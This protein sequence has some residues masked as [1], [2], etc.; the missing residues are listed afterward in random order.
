METGTAVVLYDPPAHPFSGL[1]SGP[2]AAVK[3]VVSIVGCWGGDND[4]I[5]VGTGVGSG[6]AGGISVGVAVGVVAVMEIVGA[7]G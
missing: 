5:S 7:N 4:G 1:S 2:G 3:V 6:L